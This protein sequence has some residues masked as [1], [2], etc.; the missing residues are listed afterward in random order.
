MI[1]IQ[2]IMMIVGNHKTFKKYLKIDQL[3]NMKIILK[4]KIKKI[5]LLKLVIIV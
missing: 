3:I 1:S 5:N 4:F 2:V